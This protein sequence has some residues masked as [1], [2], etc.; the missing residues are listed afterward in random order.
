MRRGNGHV[1]GGNRYLVPFIRGIATT[2]LR[3]GLAMTEN[4]G[5]KPLNNN[6]SFQQ[7]ISQFFNQSVLLYRTDCI[8]W[9]ETKQ[10]RL[11]TMYSMR[12]VQGHVQVYDKTGKFLFSAD[13]EREAREELEDYAESAA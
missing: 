6:L 1:F 9:S 13:T 7:F 5:A 4:F 2:S 8:L 11:M 10:E 3:T 12:Y